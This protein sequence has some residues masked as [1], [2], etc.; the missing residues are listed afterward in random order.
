MSRAAR[1]VQECGCV[2]ETQQIPRSMH[3]RDI[4]TEFCVAHD[5]EN[6]SLKAEAER[7]YRITQEERALREEFTS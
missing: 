1:H 7:G 3:T 2:Y 4:W 6:K 5:A